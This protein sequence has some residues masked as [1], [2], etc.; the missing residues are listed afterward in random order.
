MPLHCPSKVGRPIRPTQPKR[1]GQEIQ[2]GFV[3][4]RTP[5]VGPKVRPQTRYTPDCAVSKHS[6]RTDG[7][8]NTSADVA[9]PALS[10]PISTSL[11]N[12]SSSVIDEL[13]RLQEWN[14]RRHD[15]ERIRQ[16]LLPV[17]VRSSYTNLDSGR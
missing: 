10:N 7:H 12:I 2:P 9:R 6:R 16:I 1:D 15:A 13:T 11:E 17:H 8:A 5:S 4:G 14:T 3:A